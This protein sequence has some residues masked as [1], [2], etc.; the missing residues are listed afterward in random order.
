[1]R[2]MRLIVILMAGILTGLQQSASSTGQEKLRAPA[3][4]PSEEVIKVTITTGGGFYGPVKDQFKVGEAI[5]VVISMTDPG[6]KP[7]KYCLSTSILQNRPQLKKDGQLIPYLTNLPQQIETEDVIQRCET[8]AARQ[9]HE[10]Q[11]KQTKVVDWFTISQQ[12]IA[13]YKPLSP[14]HYELVLQRRL[15]C[16]RGPMVESNQVAFDVVP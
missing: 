4:A 1:V 2:K 15:E 5:P 3:T 12:G 16:C 6:D 11:P 9:L 8:S 13:W 10:L 14:G 7:A